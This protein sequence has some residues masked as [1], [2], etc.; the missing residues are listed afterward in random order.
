[1]I[2]VVLAIGIMM[3]VGFFGGKLAHRFK[4]PMVTGYIAVGILL[5]PSLLNII[6]QATIDRLE[7]FTSI[8]LASS[9]ILSAA[10]S[11]S[12]HCERWRGVL[13]G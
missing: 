8:A 1:M 13:P 7:V 11:V 6:P 3:V 12:N 5:S 9:P 4:A 2:D 10:V